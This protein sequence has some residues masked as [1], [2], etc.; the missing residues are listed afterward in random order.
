M[1]KILWILL[2]FA[3]FTFAQTEE[4]EN[5]KIFEINKMPAHAAFYG[6]RSMDAAIKNDRTQS[7]FFKSLNGTWKFKWVIKPADKPLTFFQDGFDLSKWDDITV[8]GNW[9]LQGFGK[10]LYLDEEYPFKPNPPFVP[11]DW[12]PVGSY[13]RSFTI[14]KNWNGQ[15]III[16]FAAAKS[17]MHVWINGKKVGYS[18]GSKLP[19]EFD[20]TKYVRAGENTVS[21]QI[22]RFSD[23]VYLE[24]QDYWRLSGFERDVYLY[25]KPKVSIRD[26]FL[27]NGLDAKYKDGLFGLDLELQ[28]LSAQTAEK[29]TLSVSL[30]DKQGEEIFKEEKSTQVAGEGKNDVHFESRI[31]NPKKWSAETPYLYTLFV[32]M[33]NAQG[34]TIEAFTH[35][36][37][38]RSV[39]IK[40]GQLLVNGI[41]VYLK[42]VNRH[43]HDPKN[44]RVISEESMHQDIK[45]MKQYNINAVRASHYPNQ[46]RW[47]ELCD[48]YGLY[49]VDEANIE[50]HGMGYHP[51]GYGLLSDNP[52]WKDAYIARTSRMVERDKNYTSIIIWSLGNEA[53][54]GSNFVHTYNWIKGRDKSRP[55][56][57]Q[58]AWY[59][60]HTDIVCPMYRNPEFIEGYAK[61]Y[62]D[63]PLILCEYDHA[64]GN[65]VGNLQ[66]YWDVMEK[67]K[68]L[69]GGFIWD[70]VDQTFERTNS[71]GVKYWAYGGDLNTTKVMND[72]N[73]CANGLVHADRSPVPHIM[74]V[75]KVYQYIKAEALDLSKARIRIR[76]KYDFIDLS[77]FYFKWEIK[78]DGKVLAKGPLEVGALAARSH[79]ELVVPIPLIQVQPAT[80]YFLNIKAYSKKASNAVPKDHLVAWDQLKMP[81]SKPAIALAVNNG[82]KL[83]MVQSAELYQLSNGAIELQISKKSGFISQIKH[84]GASILTSELKPNFWRAPT[85]NDLGFKMQ[86]KYKFWQNASSE[87]QLK[88]IKHS[89]KEQNIHEVECHYSHP[90]KKFNYKIRYTMHTSGDIFVENSLEPTVKDLS[91]I[92]RFGMQVELLESFTKVAW[93]GR[94]PHE[95]Y[96]DRKWSADVD[97]YSGNVEDQFFRYVR[98]QETGNK[99]D[100]RWMALTNNNGVGIMAQGASFLEMSSWPFKST[101]LDWVSRS[102][103]HGNEIKTGGVVT[104]NIDHKQMGVGG[105]NS[106]GA[107]PHKPYM[108]E[109]IKRSYTFR[110]RVFNSNKNSALQLSKQ[111][112]DITNE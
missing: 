43:E 80:E 26:F 89:I 39:E 112:T 101:A 93:L 65:S 28:N 92:P 24:C 49:V 19:A 21:A 56:Q 69:Q 96:I 85:D 74:E 64:M 102:Q 87:M 44:G 55:V 106:W 63:R 30:K 23:G 88:T 81:W 98:P 40:D 54:D 3:S 12:N 75:K 103:A 29:I 104:L 47:Y 84:N 53:G 52:D 82:L 15:Q 34:K 57:Y 61:K 42:G 13:K 8:P 22:Y 97:L 35:K 94:G 108:I 50:C 1:Q 72:S 111:K 5:P 59:K 71:E 31:K 90:L 95:N 6:Y 67:Y 83:Q 78:A 32:E 11:H 41:A 77:G 62:S 25:A 4:W 46:Y 27:H 14:P 76:N 86:Q 45:L 2:L 60:A 10:P 107:K 33:K 7:P 66:D 91:N 18:Q 70:W 36:M 9:E 99:T 105:D 17:A 58:P 38:F 110:L 51:E 37:G 79:K 16:H 109:P 73:F 20:I 48:E 68:V 100:V